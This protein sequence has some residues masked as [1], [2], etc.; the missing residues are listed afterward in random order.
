MKTISVRWTLYHLMRNS[1]PADY[2]VWKHTHHMTITWS[3]HAHTKCLLF[4]SCAYRKNLITQLLLAY[5]G[6]GQGS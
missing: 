6:G 4:V 2:H 5:A 3:G 1:L